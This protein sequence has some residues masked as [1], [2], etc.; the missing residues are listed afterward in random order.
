MTDVADLAVLI[1]G[2]VS[3]KLTVVTDV[4]IPAEDDLED[5]HSRDVRLH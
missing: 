2:V 3:C 4:C 1:N 5:Q